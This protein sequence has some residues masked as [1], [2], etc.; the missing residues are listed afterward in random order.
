MANVSTSDL[1]ARIDA[2]VKKRAA[3]EERQTRAE[4]DLAEAEAALTELGLTPKTARRVIEE[5]EAALT[6][7]VAEVEKTLGLA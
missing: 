1:R 6:A 7:D 5:A 3:L 2:C 4:H